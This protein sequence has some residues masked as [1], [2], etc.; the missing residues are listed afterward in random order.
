MNENPKC[1]NVTILHCK[2]TLFGVFQQAMEPQYG[3][4][5][6]MSGAMLPH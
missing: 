6:E 1:P 5:L 3:V 2:V 4:F